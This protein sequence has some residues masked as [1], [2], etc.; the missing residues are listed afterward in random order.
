M[1]FFV[2]N[3]RGLGN[4]ETVRELHHLVR[5]QVPAL[6]FISETKIEGS[7]V[8]DLTNRLGFA[9]CVPVSS[10]GLSGG[11]ALF[12]S[13]ELDVTLNNY[14]DQHI[15]VKVENV[16]SFRK[17]WRFTGFYAKARRS[18]RS[19]SWERLRQLNAQSSLPWLCGGDFNEITDN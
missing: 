13:H 16:G 2:W 11:L 12:W 6:V 5:V 1:N 3:C 19:Q 15:D 17:T 8:T 10:S 18:E 7:R 9:G 14:S 4:P